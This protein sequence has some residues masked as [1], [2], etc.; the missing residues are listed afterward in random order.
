MHALTEN[1]VV[2]RATY[3]QTTRYHTR[4]PYEGIAA[5]RQHLRATFIE[6]FV[7]HYIGGSTSAVLKGRVYS[8]FLLRYIDST[9]S[10]HKKKKKRIYVQLH[11]KAILVTVQ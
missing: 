11:T 1:G 2:S 10:M 4:G 6:F 5:Q 9:L 3:S 8:V 7:F